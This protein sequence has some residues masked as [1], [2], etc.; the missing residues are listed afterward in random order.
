MDSLVRDIISR[1]WILRVKIDSA[2]LRVKII[3]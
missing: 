2:A 1:R 3:T